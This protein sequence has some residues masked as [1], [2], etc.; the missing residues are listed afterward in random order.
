M[1]IVYMGQESKS[2]L[3]G[4]GKAHPRGSFGSESTD[5][6]EFLLQDIAVEVEQGIEGLVLSGG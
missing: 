4:G 2:F 6:R 1:N 3:A 5:I